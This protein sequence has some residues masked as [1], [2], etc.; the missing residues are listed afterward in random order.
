MSQKPG[1]CSLSLEQIDNFV[2]KES[3]APL[4]LKLFAPLALSM[5]LSS[6]IGIVDMYLAACIG[7]RA[8]AAVGLGDQ[9]LFLLIV[10]GTGLASACNSFVSRCKGAGDFHSCKKFAK[11]SLLIAFVFGLF[12]SVLGI[13]CAEPFLDLLGC[14]PELK[15][16][17]VP[18]VQF[19]SFANAPFVLLLCLSAIFRSLARPALAVYLWLFTA[20]L[21]NGLSIALF[22]SGFANSKSLNA[23]A[24]GWDLGSSMAFVFGMFLYFKIINQTQKNMGSPVAQRAGPGEL[25]KSSKQLILLAAPAVLAELSLILSQFFVYRFLSGVEHSA[26]LQAAWTIK[27]K[28]EESLALMPLMALGMSTSVI[29]GQSVGANNTSRAS[30]ATK[31]ICSA[32]VL[33][34]FLLGGLISLVSS[35]MANALGD[36]AISRQAIVS[37]LLPSCILYPLCAASSLLI[38][39]MEGAGQTVIP[40]LLNLSFLVLARILLTCYFGAHDSTASSAIGWGQCLSQLLLVAGCLACFPF[41]LDDK[42]IYGRKLLG[43]RTLLRPAEKY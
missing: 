35:A 43:W 34:L 12:A 14:G 20:V 26:S 28:I 27:M 39:A 30:Y 16:L 1:L 17:A 5:M 10:F 23:L 29:V 15:E 6:S 31:Q 8:Q 7:S 25:M 22:F 32:S 13:F 19:S 42:L 4:T 3:I 38:A 18:Y 24:I 37:F 33:T 40:M 36:D 2:L 41:S 9:L 11:C 21:S